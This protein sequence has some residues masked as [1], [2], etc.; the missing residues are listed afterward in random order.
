[1][2]DMY[3]Y[4]LLELHGRSALLSMEERFEAIIST[5]KHL[6]KVNLYWLHE[7][8]SNKIFGVADLVPM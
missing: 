3:L 2:P 1:M 6:W 7:M 5:Y 4:M 8:S